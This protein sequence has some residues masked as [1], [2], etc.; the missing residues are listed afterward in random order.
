MEYRQLGRDG[1]FVS[2]IGFGTWPIGGKGYGI[3][4]DTDV[5]CAVDRAID[6]GITLFD[7][8][9][10]Y[11]GG[12][13]EEF[14]GR[15]LDGRRARVVLLTKGGLTI[16]SAGRVAGRDSRPAA[17]VAGLEGSLRRLRTDYADVYLIHWPDRQTP[18]EEAMNG[19][20][21]ILASGMARRVGV[22]NFPSAELERCR[23]LAPLVANQVACSLFD[24]RWEMAMFPTA[25]ALGVG[26]LAYGPLAHGLLG[27]HYQADHRFAP[28]DWRAE[29]RTLASP[30][31][32]VGENFGHNLALVE[33]IRAIAKAGGH[34]VAQVALAW[35]LRDPL[36]AAAITSPRRIDQVEESAAAS[37]I[38]LSVEEAAALEKIAAEVAG[39]VAFL[40]H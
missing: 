13:A 11:G 33:R 39:S 15:V 22:S 25:R 40:P 38:K 1:P 36:V 8:A 27:G 31:F 34:T 20:N 3:A 4:N 28:S 26:I 10:A 17:L 6:L 16:D 32:L 23:A 21:Q 18:W 14:L 35:V 7:T 5:E 12:Y 19:L 29:G 9:P 2:T 24:R 30:E 37:S